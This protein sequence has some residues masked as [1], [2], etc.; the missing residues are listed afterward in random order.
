[1]CWVVGT[2]TII[3]ER[4]YEGMGPKMF[5]LTDPHSQGMSG[6]DALHSAF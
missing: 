6:C 4:P 3:R 1:M 5:I 2:V